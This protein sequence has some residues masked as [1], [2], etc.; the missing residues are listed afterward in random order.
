MTDDMAV[1]MNG[2]EA[3]TPWDELEWGPWPVTAVLSQTPPDPSLLGG[4]EGLPVTLTV[5]RGEGILQR[6]VFDPSLM[7]YS[8]A[9]RAGEPQFASPELA[10]R[11]HE[12]RCQ[13][14]DDVIAAIAGSRWAG[15]LVLRGSILLKAWYGDAAREPGDLD[16]VVVPQTWLMTEPRTGRMLDDIAQ[17]SAAAAAEHGVVRIDAENAMR[18]EI[19]TYSRVPGM[20]LVLPWHA[21]GLP[22]GT[23]QLDFVF[24][25]R[26][27]EEPEFTS[28]PAR[29]TDETGQRILAATPALS[30]AWKLLWLLSDRYPQGKDLYDA[31]LLAEA[32][33][34]PL[35]LLMRTLVAAEPEWA[36]RRFTPDALD[37]LD[38]DEDELRKDYPEIADAVEPLRQRL[39]AALAPTFA[40][41]AALPAA[42][43]YTWRL[44]H[45]APRIAQARELLQSEDVDAVLTYVS[46]ESLGMTE[47]IVVFREALGAERCSLEDA[48]A[49]LLEFRL[50]GMSSESYYRSRFTTFI[51]RAVTEL[52]ENV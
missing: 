45:L 12:A 37:E 39:I 43:G 52:G 21:E 8:K 24:N 47:C 50:R 22:S 27:P 14:L 10:A 2:G 7:S 34:L 17:A 23:V 15:N 25:E 48:A 35:G 41:S 19:W 1:E 6:P 40:E 36:G 49:T 31:V 33:P 29:A 26:L 38:I 11:W 3:V 51:Q 18:D 4:D 5:I 16:F 42:D 32:A 46:E 20:R 9:M 28:V 30:L 44:G 13:A